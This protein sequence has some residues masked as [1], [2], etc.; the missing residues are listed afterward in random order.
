M[1]LLGFAARLLSL[2]RIILV[3]MAA[4]G[5]KANAGGAHDV[6]ESDLDNARYK[7]ACPGYQHYAVFPQ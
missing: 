2:S 3:A 5:E 6:L 7:P 1:V 4:A